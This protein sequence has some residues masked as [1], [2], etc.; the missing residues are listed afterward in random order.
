[1]MVELHR[2]LANRYPW[3]ISDDQDDDE[4]CCVPGCPHP[5][6]RSSPCCYGHTVDTDDPRHI[7]GQDA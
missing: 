6:L 1:M 4:T 5:T 2:S 7:G 3:L